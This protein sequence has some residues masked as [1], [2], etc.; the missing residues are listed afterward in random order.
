MALW[1]HLAIRSRGVVSEMQPHK[2]AETFKNKPF[3]PWQ[4]EY[5]HSLSLLL[6]LLSLGESL[7]ALLANF[8]N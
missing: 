1:T 4:D 8:E 6:V 7:V 5:K 3:W 2:L